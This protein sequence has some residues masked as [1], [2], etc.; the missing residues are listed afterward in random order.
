MTEMNTED[1]GW[2]DIHCK[3]GIPGFGP[4]AFEVNTFSDL[5]Q[6]ERLITSYPW[7][8]YEDY[9]DLDELINTNKYFVVYSIADY[10]AYYGWG[11]EDPLNPSI[12]EGFAT[13]YA[14]KG[15]AAFLGLIRESR[16]YVGGVG[17]TEAA[18]QHGRFY[19][20]LYGLTD[21]CRTVWRL[22]GPPE[23][24]SKQKGHVPLD[25]YKVYMSYMA[26]SHNLFGSPLT[27]VWTKDNP[28]PLTAEHPISW[29]EG[30]GAPFRVKV[31]EGNQPV[32]N[33]MVTLLLYSGDYPTGENVNV[34]ARALTGPNGVA[35]FRIA[36]TMSG[37]M[38]VT[39]TK[40]DYLPY[41]GTCQVSI[42]GAKRDRGQE[43]LPENLGITAP[44]VSSGNCFI[45]LAIPLENEGQASLDL[46][47][48]T[49]RLSTRVYDGYLE[50]GYH[51]FNLDKKLASGVYF[52]RLET[53]PCGLSRKLVVK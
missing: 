10:N 20:W 37:Q 39:A 1:W 38:K 18:R 24:F 22:L 5:P 28:K 16:V 30:I 51:E 15:A 8:G 53:G 47:D 17:L 23:S 19:Q 4:T 33:A 25:L 21:V 27:P 46:Y 45:L 43:L 35:T 7:T 12:M 26:Y 31:K 14:S 32:R 29:A 13:Y 49:G 34:Y 52:L 50:A 40:H 44:T 2:I 6:E 3:G 48:A 42:G 11:L 9:V 36:P 41:M